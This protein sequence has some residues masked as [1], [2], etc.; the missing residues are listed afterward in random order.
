[1]PLT[2]RNGTVVTPAGSRLIGPWHP[3][4]VVRPG[5][6]GE[7]TDPGRSALSLNVIFW[8]QVI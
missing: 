5:S 7:R 4:D 3:N 6:M 8:R 2:V 1:M